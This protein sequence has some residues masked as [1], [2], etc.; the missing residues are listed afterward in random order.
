MAVRRSMFWSFVGDGSMIFSSLIT[1][2]IVAR[3][4]TPAQMGIFAI[5][6][7]VMAVL[8]SMAQMDDEPRS[9]RPRGAL[10][11]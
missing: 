8:Q 1:A 2:V 11:V 3:L 7:A 5:A 4:L 9:P 10:M 6:I